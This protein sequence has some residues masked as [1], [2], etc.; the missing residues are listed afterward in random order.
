[1][2][3]LSTMVFIGDLWKFQFLPIEPKENVDLLL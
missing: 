2:Y 1:M 3:A